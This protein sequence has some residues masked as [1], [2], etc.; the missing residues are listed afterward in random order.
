M[1]LI[2]VKDNTYCIDAG[3][4]YIPLYK[5]NEK[6]I[7]LLDTG[8]IDEKEILEEVFEQNNFNVKGIIC[9]HGHPDHVGNNQYFKKKYN[10]PI[11]MPE[12]EAQIFSSAMNL[13]V[14]YNNITFTDI[15]K[16]YGH[17]IFE[18]DECITVNQEEI[19]FCG[20][21]FKITHTPG[22]SASH[23]CITTPDDVCYLADALIGYEL[24]ATTKM[25]FDFALLEAIKSREKLRNIHCSKYIATHKGI[26]DNIDR[27][28]TDNIEFYKYRSEKICQLITEKM[29][30]DEIMQ[31]ALKTFGV[32]TGSVYKFGIIHRMLG[33][34][35]DYLY[36]TGR[37]CISID[38]GLLKYERTEES[39]RI[40]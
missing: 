39:I 12:F 34:F 9:S 3:M 5:L 11:A 35:I 22:H 30:M 14:F 4:S 36:E 16:Y 8:T 24:M 19:S 1:K 31:R 26:Y 2:H 21:E 25:P 17:L 23:I 40:R 27:L 13:K 10:C 37:L 29:T 38:N 7:I 32:R 15:E 18:T 6:D 28:I 33:A 20:A